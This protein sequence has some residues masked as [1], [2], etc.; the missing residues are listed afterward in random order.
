M[1]PGF[2]LRGEYHSTTSPALGE[3]EARVSVKLLLTNNHPVPT[4]AFRAGAPK[5]ENFLQ[6]H[7]GIK[8]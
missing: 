3:V 7:L 2:F 8:Q 5:L 1:D 6:Q 4:P